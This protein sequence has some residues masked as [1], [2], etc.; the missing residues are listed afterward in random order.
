MRVGESQ[1]L[2][3]CYFVVLSLKQKA[4]IG[5]LSSSKNAEIM[6]ATL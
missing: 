4:M 3:L 5:W 6:M 2:Q 1:R